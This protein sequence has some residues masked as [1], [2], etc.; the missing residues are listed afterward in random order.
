MF[1]EPLNPN[2]KIHLDAWLLSVVAVLLMIGV[3]MELK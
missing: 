1:K 2:A 3:L